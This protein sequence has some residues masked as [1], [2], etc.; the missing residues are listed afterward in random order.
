MEKITIDNFE[1]EYID[2]VEQ[3]QID[4]FVCDEML[5][6]IHRYIKAM[7]GS[8]TIMN[9]FDKRLKDCS[10]V[11]REKAIADY[12]NFNRKVLNG[13][14]YK[15]ILTRSFA[16]YCDSF[17]YFVTMIQNKEKFDYYIQRIHDKYER[18]HELFEEN[19]KYGIKDFEGN[20]MITPN[21]D[22]LRTCRHA[23]VDD[24]CMMPVI[25]E[26]NGKLGLILPDGKDTVLA[27][28][29][30][31]NIEIRDEPPFFEV[32]RDGETMYI[33]RYGKVSYSL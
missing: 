23:Y 8:I 7:S 30:F 24:L 13:L 9:E 15:I 10:V 14:D 28:F 12:I 11:Q 31:D 20:I 25:A 4:K 29:V 21:Y 3:A 33:N 18:F 22:F 19:G 2:G 32:T 26:K 6:Q 16:N 1:R 17:D 5:R 27:D